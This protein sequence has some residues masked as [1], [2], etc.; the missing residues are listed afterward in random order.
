MTRKSIRGLIVLAL[1]T[2]AFL[3]VMLPAGASDAPSPVYVYFPWVPNG[4][5]ID[6]PR[7]FG[8]TGPYFGTIRVTNPLDE[9]VRVFVTPTANGGILDGGSTFILNLAAYES[10]FIYPVQLQIPPG[11][12]SGAMLW[13]ERA[14]DE[15]PAPIAAVLK[16]ASPTPATTT[17]KTDESHEIVSG[18]T[19]IAGEQ[20]GNMA[21]LPIVQTNSNWQTII[22]ATNLDPGFQNTISV[23]LYEADGGGTLGPFE[24]IVQTGDTATFDLLDLGVPDGWVGSAVISANLDVAAIAERVKNET[25]MLIINP[26]RYPELGQLTPTVDQYAPLVF[27]EWFDWNTGIS[28]ANLAGVSNDVV[29]R[30]Y[31][32]DGTHV[33][34][35]ELTLPP[36]GMNFIF[37]PG[38]AGDAAFVG[39][40][41]IES[42]A[43]VYGVVDEVKYTGDQ[44]DGAGHA[45]SYVVDQGY[46]AATQGQW[47]VMPLY[48]KGDQDT[49]LGD[50][51]GIQL[52]NPSDEP[53]SYWYTRR[54]TDGT[55]TG[56]VIPIDPLGPK[57]GTTIY[58]LDTPGLPSGFSGS[59][60]IYVF[61]GNGGLVGISNNVNYEVQHDGSAAF[62]LVRVTPPPD[63]PTPVPG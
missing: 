4:I 8:T 9:P 28:L 48:Q 5:T 2:S 61:G 63:T 34:T 60:I 26:S 55:S 12:G 29:V 37:L 52:F 58:A 39:S 11:E 33:H 14:S 45:M 49:G 40:A 41:I 20:I 43:P 22:R 10:T 36:N 7:G 19:G 15:T 6:D 17:F 23:T 31:A 16:Q 38:G 32:P 59:I 47:L 35:E 44:A 24:Q 54:N 30:F 25:N 53:V 62:N 46:E 13:G 42:Q 50:T 21:V 27:R 1:A 56:A 51:S 3:A 18:Y 57:Q